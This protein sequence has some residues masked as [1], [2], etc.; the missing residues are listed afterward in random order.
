MATLQE[1][2][3]RDNL[4]P[5]ELAEHL[6]RLTHEQRLLE[7]RAL[8]GKDQAR[9]YERV[10]G[11]V[12]L[13]LDFY[14]P[15]SVGPLTEVIHHGKNSLPMFSYFQKRFCRPEADNGTLYGYNHQ[16]MS[17]FTGPGYFVVRPLPTDKRVVIDYTEVPPVKPASWPTIYPN[18][19]L[20]SRLVYYQMR[21][22][23]WK[24]SSHVSIGRAHRNGKEQP[25]WFVLTREDPA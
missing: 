17:W 21:D 8:T 5:E 12:P 10:A 19:R 25:N 6:D 14:V 16:T 15:Q 11:A 18:S 7:I 24:V 3:A 23:M 4:R 2:I 22:F 20:G 1:L 13:D 9:L